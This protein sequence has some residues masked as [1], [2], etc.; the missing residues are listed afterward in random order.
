MMMRSLVHVALA[1]LPLLASGVPAWACDSLANTP[2]AAF[3]TVAALPGS[4]V[5]AVGGFAGGKVLDEEW[6]M[7]ADGTEASKRDI[8]GRFTGMAAT[9]EGFTRSLDVPVRITQ[10]C[11]GDTC[12]PEADGRRFLVFL[13]ARGGA[14][15]FRESG[16]CAILSYEAPSQAVLDKM[17]GCL[18]GTC[19]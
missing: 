9:P 5:V 4:Y 17:I 10:F 13:E 15:A 11:M 12:K 7:G 6:V 3:R 2:V 8:S 14:Y 1:A 19:K 16:T 18:N